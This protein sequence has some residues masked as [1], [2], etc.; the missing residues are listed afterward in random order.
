MEFG[1]SVGD[2]TEAV[3]C[4]DLLGWRYGRQ[5]GERPGTRKL[6]GVER[7]CAPQQRT[8]GSSEA[9]GMGH[10]KAKWGTENFLAIGQLM[11]SCSL[12]RELSPAF[13]FFPHRQTRGLRRYDVAAP[14][15]FSPPRNTGLCP[16]S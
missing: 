7:G 11:F 14:I 4:W 3:H 9:A 16:G 5:K 15:F 6:V 2:G 12:S 10:P 13:P 8:D 1:S